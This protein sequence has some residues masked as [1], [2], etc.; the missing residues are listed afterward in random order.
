MSAVPRS[1]SVPVLKSRG[2]VYPQDRIEAV[3]K[4]AELPPSYRVVPRRHLPSALGTVSADS[5]FCSKDDVYTVLYASPDFATAFFETVVRDRLVRRRRREIGLVE[6][7]ERGW[8][9]IHTMPGT[10]LLLLDLRRDGCSLVGAP[11][12]VV[13]ARNHAAGRAFGRVVH[14]E[15]P[16]VDGLLY[17]SRLTGSDVYAVF[18]RGIGKLEVRESG[19]LWDH[20][21]LPDVLARHRIDLVIEQ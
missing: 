10:T 11:T 12:D 2:D 3:L 6:V 16:N 15:H 5:R 7:T 4:E 18:D 21:D 13:N 14:A 8:G 1:E 19:M 9:H 20:P 17:A